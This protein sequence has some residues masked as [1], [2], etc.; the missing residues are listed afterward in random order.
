MLTGFQS[1]RLL[2]AS[3]PLWGSVG[4]FS[5]GAA[6]HV[7]EVTPGFLDCSDTNVQILTGGLFF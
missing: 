5:T 6:P 1:K 4:I 2:E 3:C 7:T